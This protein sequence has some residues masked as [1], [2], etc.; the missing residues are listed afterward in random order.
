MEQ[1]R[2]LLLLALV[3]GAM[4]WCAA[5]AKADDGLNIAVPDAGL[6]TI[7]DPNDALR[8]ARQ[9]ILAHDL[10]GAVYEL[11]RYVTNHPE[12]YAVERFLADL[13]FSEGD[14]HDAELTY[15]QMLDEFPLDRDLH[16]Q[17]GKL[18]TIEGENDAAILQFDQALPNVEAVYYLVVLHE[19]K[20]DLTAFDD[21]M[22]RLADSRP[23]DADAQ[24]EAAQVFGALYLPRDA[25][26]EFERALEIKPN[27]LDALEG[28]G[29]SQTAEGAN[30]GA[31]E[32]LSRCLLLDA[33][34]YG[35]L[36]AL[37]ILE[38]QE[39][40]Y[41]EAQATLEHAYQLAPEAPEAILSLA[42]LSEARGDWQG[43]I[44]LYQKAIYVWPYSGDGYVG[45][46]FDEEEH[47]RVNDAIEMTLKGL[48]IVPDDARLHYMLGYLYRMQGRR[49]LALAQFVAAE[50]SLDPEIV[51]FAKE[52]AAELQP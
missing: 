35:C 13:Y 52:S 36:D 42:R 25:A 17:L 6:T 14:L 22:R 15:R 10:P 26:T 31:E 8:F 49:D 20:G 12:E 5:A 11:E 46:A 2:R 9:R 7:S 40:H 50:K 16:T 21:S 34:D 37:G 18:Y 4:L 48:S 41:D 47:G 43:A 23:N 44:A 27:S 24:I 51:R 29:L 45:I 30:S 32:T 1:G 3:A 19:R 28:L 33:Q 39:R 38:T